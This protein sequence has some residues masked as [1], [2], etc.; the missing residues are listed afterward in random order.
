M[1]LELFA[2]SFYLFYC[3]RYYTYDEYLYDAVIQ[4]TIDSACGFDVKVCCGADIGSD[5]ANLCPSSHKNLEL[6]L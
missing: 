3:Q 4:I 5:H 2:K 6:T 1:S